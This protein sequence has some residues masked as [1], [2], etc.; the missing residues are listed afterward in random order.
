MIK[1]TMLFLNYVI[2]RHVKA[3]FSSLILCSCYNHS[4]SYINDVSF[5]ETLIGG[6]K[7]K[8]N[9]NPHRVK[10]NKEYI[11]SA[12]RLTKQLTFTSLKFA[13]TL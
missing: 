3:V 7:I 10:L 1:M 11:N 9:P 8:G 5:G 6:R 4:F 2:S 13:F 12:E